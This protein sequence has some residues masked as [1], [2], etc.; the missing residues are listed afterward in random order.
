MAL[1]GCGGEPQCEISP[2][3]PSS[4]ASIPEPE[5][6]SEPEPEPGPLEQVEEQTLTLNLARWEAP[7]E[8]VYTG[9]VLNGLPQG[10]GSFTTQSPEGEAWRYTGEWEA[11]HLEGEGEMSWGETGHSYVG[12]FSDDLCSGPGQQYFSGALLYDGVFEDDAI[13]SGKMYD[14]SGALYYEGAFRDGLRLEDE[15]AASARLVACE[16]EAVPYTAAMYEE[17]LYNHLGEL[18][19]Y[20]GVVNEMLF[21]LET[22][23]G[24]EMY[25]DLGGGLLVSSQITYRFAYGE[26]PHATGQRLRVFARV[27][28]LS[29]TAGA[30]PTAFGTQMLAFAVL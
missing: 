26:A 12:A 5:P 30:N 29:Q 28:A 6:V 25:I 22:R 2:T 13:T 4:A 8:G 16:K 19:V 18:L 24:L 20:E 27:H 7:R 3:P 21:T 11:G 1:A 14:D 23:E 17:G 15:A 9:E 10:Q